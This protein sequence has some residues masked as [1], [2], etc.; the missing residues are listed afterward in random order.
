MKPWGGC[1]QDPFSVAHSQRIS[2]NPDSKF[3]RRVLSNTAALTSNRR[4][5]G[6]DLAL[7]FYPETETNTSPSGSLHFEHANGCCFGRIQGADVER[8]YGLETAELVQYGRWFWP[9]MS[10]WLVPKE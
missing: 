3:G 2:T 9:S 6:E 1:V 8:V 4:D 7:S 5:P 10:I